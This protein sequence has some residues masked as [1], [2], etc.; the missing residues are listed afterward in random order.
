MT[1][2]TRDIARKAFAD[3]G[4]TTAVINSTNLQDL[5]KRINQKMLDAGLMGGTFKM[6]RVLGLRSLW[7]TRVAELRC[8]SRSF[9]S[10]EAVTF[11]QNGFIGFAGWAD[12]E[13]VQPILEG[14][15]EWVS[16]LGTVKTED[17]Q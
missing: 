14:F 3:A 12:E 15:I 13:N 9:E 2:L 7:G 4:H 1:N 5:I 17:S 6:R 11:N 16:A 10:R 8:K